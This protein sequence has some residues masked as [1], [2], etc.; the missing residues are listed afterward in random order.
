[1]IKLFLVPIVLLAAGLAGCSTIACGDPHPYINSESHPLLKAPPGLSVPAA[2][3]NY[4]IQGITPNVTKS[5]DR[6]AA[7]VCLIKPPQLISA[8][9][10]ATPKPPTIESKSTPV[11]SSASGKSPAQPAESDKTAAPSALSR[12]APPAVATAWHIG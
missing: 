1:M 12:S 6:D 10:A 2:D 8:Q 4:A 3:P 5:T 11:P 9:P 7:G